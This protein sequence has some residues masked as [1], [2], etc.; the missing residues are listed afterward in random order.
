MNYIKNIFGTK[1]QS[2]KSY[3]EFWEWFIKHEK[4]F[5]NVV[6]GRKN[7]EKDFFN[8]LS[9]KLSELKDG[10]FYLTGM[11]DDNTVELIF[12]PD[13][14]VKNIVF[15]EEL[16][17]EAP[18]ING[19]VFTALKP[20][21][22][23]KDVNIEMAGYKFNKDNLSFYYNKKANYPDEID[24]TIVYSDYDEE[25]KNQITSG[26]LI[27][28]DNCLGELNF[29]TS[30]DN[31]NVEGNIASSKELIPIEKLKDFIN[32]KQKEFV[33]KYEGIRH[34][35]ANDNYSVLEA[36]LENG[37]PLLAVVDTDLLNWDRK[38]SHPWI[39]T[40]EVKYNGTTNNGLPDKSTTK[41][42]EKIE[43]EITD[44]LPDYKGYLNIGH[45]SAEGIRE[46]F[47][48][49]KDFRK[50]S[51]ELHQIVQR[52]KGNFEINYDIYKDK[53]WRSFEQFA[54]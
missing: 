7:I 26:A 44:Q 22:D 29:V 6:K 12:T 35:T 10:F 30:I 15:V 39:L 49:C 33:E 1:E 27:F 17:K 3:K 53:Y 24:I 51:L 28:L 41:L 4:T 25:N 50:P 45:Q 46:I 36:E 18:D 42:L 5:F 43:N 13:G 40:V 47:F 11:N 38:A 23:I 9:P 21:L 20:A 32:W 31:L 8:K 48:A 34:L 2:V 19:W 16:V 52:Y 14:I 54:K 37:N